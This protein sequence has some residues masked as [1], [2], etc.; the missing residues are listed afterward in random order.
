MFAIGNP[1]LVFSATETGQ[2]DRFPLLNRRVG[3][4]VMTANGVG[5]SGQGRVVSLNA[6]EPV[7]E[8]PV[9]VHGTLPHGA[10]VPAVQPAVVFYD[11]L[12]PGHARALPRRGARVRCQGMQPLWIHASRSQRRQRTSRG[13]TR[14][15]GGN[16]PESR[17]LIMVLLEVPKSAA[18]ST[19]SRSSLMS[20]SFS[21][22]AAPYAPLS[23]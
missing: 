2:P 21:L 9:P 12:S 15:A 6:P 20:K 7:G 19:M 5:F 8:E 23:T 1:G 16:T 10:Q 11:R 14:T 4:E 22:S 3:P 18:T 13:P 17:Y